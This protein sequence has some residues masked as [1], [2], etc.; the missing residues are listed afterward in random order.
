MKDIAPL[1]VGERSEQGFFNMKC[2]G[3]S[4][5]GLVARLSVPPCRDVVKD[6]RRV[7]QH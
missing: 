4:M 7:D 5:I 6:R 2:S 1:D 3:M